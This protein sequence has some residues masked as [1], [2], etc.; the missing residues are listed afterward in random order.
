MVSRVLMMPPPASWNWP[1]TLVDEDWDENGDLWSG[2]YSIGHQVEQEHRGCYS[3]KQLGEHRR[4]GPAIDLAMDAWDKQCAD[5]R[6][7]TGEDDE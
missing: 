4:L 3:F 6:K 5:Y 1:N 7:A 2:R